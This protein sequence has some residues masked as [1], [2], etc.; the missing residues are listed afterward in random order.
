MTREE[1]AEVLA[2]WMK[3]DDKFCSFMNDKS[4]PEFYYSMFEKVEQEFRDF[5]C[6]KAGHEIV[7]DQ[8]GKPEHRLCCYCTRS[9]RDIQGYKP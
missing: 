6:S 3:F 8:C 4:A 9:E 1:A 2:I 7:N 5:C